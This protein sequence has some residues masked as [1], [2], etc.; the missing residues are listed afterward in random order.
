[1]YST[2]GQE[3]FLKNLSLS[4]AKDVSYI[5]IISRVFRSLDH[6]ISKVKLSSCSL[7]TTQDAS[8]VLP[9]SH[10]TAWQSNHDM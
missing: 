10:K 9:F 7:V 2:G 5:I 6:E 4:V 3:V 8:P 1:M